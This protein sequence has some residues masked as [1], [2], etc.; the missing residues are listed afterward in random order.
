MQHHLGVHSDQHV[1]RLDRFLHLRRHGVEIRF[2]FIPGVEIEHRIEQV[3]QLRGAHLRNIF[4]EV[5]I[6]IA[7]MRILRGLIVGESNRGP[8]GPVNS[9]VLVPLLATNRAAVEVEM[10]VVVFDADVG[11][12]GRIAGLDRRVHRAIKLLQIRTIGRGHAVFQLE[13]LWCPWET[14]SAHRR[15]GSRSRG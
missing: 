11:N 5:D 3:A 6:E 10:N 4:V 12:V 15:F 13:S 14:R 1:V 9:N 7:A 2:F 8:V